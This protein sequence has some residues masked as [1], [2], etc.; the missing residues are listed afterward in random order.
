MTVLLYL[1]SR[2]IDKDII[3]R[4]IIEKIQIRPPKKGGLFNLKE[5]MNMQNQVQIFE[6][7]EFGKLEVLMIDGKPYFPAS[8]CAKVLGYKNP[9][10]AINDHCPHL[11][12]REVGVQTG[13]KANGTP[14]FQ[15]VEKAYIPEGDLYRLIIRSKLPSAVRFEAWIFDEV[16]PSIRKYGAY[17][18]EGIL[19]Q[20]QENSEFVDELIHLLSKEREKNDVLLDFAEHIAPKALYYDI[21]LQCPDAIQVSIIAKDYG[22]SALAFN[23]LLNE[24]GVQYKV[25][26]TWL[27]YQTYADC[28]YTISK[29]YLIDG[30]IA[31]V[32]TCWTQKGRLFLYELLKRHG[33]LPQAKRLNEGSDN[34]F[35]PR[36]N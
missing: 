28:G 10:K 8:E 17:I 9:H 18:M 19:E 12:K 14:A 5:E 30:M 35:S 24:L 7:N 34:Y 22:M 31:S 36:P 16:L 4:H 20:M 15:Q 32:H 27:L 2:G 33:I 11:T 13:I 1:R 25:G 3:N 23:K 26:K 29:T 6:N 21:I